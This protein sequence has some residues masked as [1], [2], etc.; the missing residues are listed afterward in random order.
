ME[1]KMAQKYAALVYFEENLYE[2]VG[3]NTTIT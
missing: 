1:A 3:K 2:I